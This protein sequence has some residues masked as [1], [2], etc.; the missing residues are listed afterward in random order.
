MIDELIRDILNDAGRAPHGAASLMPQLP[1]GAPLLE[2]VLLTE[3][4][5]GALADALAPALATALAP[6]ILQLMG[7]GESEPAKRTA[8]TGARSKTSG[9]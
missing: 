7:G 5:A 8:G 3:V 6:R 4:M 9:K 1:R 2:R